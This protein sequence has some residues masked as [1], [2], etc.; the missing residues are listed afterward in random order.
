MTVL[1]GFLSTEYLVSTF[2]IDK[3]CSVDVV[4]LMV[5]VVAFAYLGDRQAL[6]NFFFG[7]PFDLAAGANSAL[8][9]RG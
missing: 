4:G 6:A 9:V 7:H 8:V 1:D 2:S 3:S 5:I